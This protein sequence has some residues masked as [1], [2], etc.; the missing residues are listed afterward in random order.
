MPTAVANALL[1][2][3]AHP[4][5]T[6]P[7]AHLLPAA[8]LGEQAKW[9]APQGPGPGS[10][11]VELR[12]AVKE[13]DWVRNYEEGLTT[14]GMCAEWSASSERCELLATVAGSIGARR[15]LEI[16]SFCGVAA[17]ALARALPED[18]RVQALEIDPFVVALGQRFSGK[19]P[20]G[21][22]ITTR[23]GAASVSLE[24][25]ALEAR[26]GVL[27]PFDLAVVDADKAGMRGYF[28]HLWS[29]P[30]L[31]G[32]G[33]VVC[34]DLTPFKGQPPL[35]YVKFGFPYPWEASSGQEEIEALRA[36]IAASPQF[37]SHEVG[38]LLVVQRASRAQ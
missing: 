22:K 28:D 35:R 9:S 5:A 27:E 12:R 7:N 20:A 21:R 34:V 26:A 6:F 15:V 24:A 1:A 10:P 31:L 16:G 13:E 25:M 2:S 4:T 11:L 33:A 36:Y 14:M 19:C 8:A 32:E 23:V 17:L 29:K 3:G 30:G 18:A 38:L 37:V